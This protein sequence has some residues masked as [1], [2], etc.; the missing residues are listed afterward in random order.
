[1]LFHG[2]QHL[3]FLFNES[4][5]PLSRF[6]DAAAFFPKAPVH[7]DTF[8]VSKVILCTP[9]G[10]TYPQRSR[11]EGATEVLSVHDSPF[12]SFSAVRCTPHRPLPK[13]SG[14]AGGGSPA[15]CSSFFSGI[16]TT[17]LAG[18]QGWLKV[19]Q[20]TLNKRMHSLNGNTTL[21]IQHLDGQLTSYVELSLDTLLTP[22]AQESAC[23]SRQRLLELRPKVTTRELIIPLTT[24]QLDSFSTP[25]TSSKRTGRRRKFFINNGEVRFRKLPK[26]RRSHTIKNLQ[27]SACRRPP[28]PRGA[29][30]APCGSHEECPQTVVG[31]QGNSRGAMRRR[32]QRRAY[33]RWCR[34]SNKVRGK[35][36][37]PPSSVPAKPKH[38]AQTRAKWFRQHIFWQE[39]M[40]RKKTGKATNLPTTTPLGYAEVVRFGALSVQGFADTLKLKNSIQLMQEHRL[41]V[42]FMSETKSTS[43]YSYLSEQ[44]LVILSGNN[45]QK[46]AG[47]GAI[48]SPRIR[49]HLLD[50]IQVSSRLI[51]L[52]FKKKGGNIHLLGAY[53]PHS[54]LDLEEERQPFW[55][56]LEETI[57]KIPQPEPVYV[58]GDFNVRFQ[59]SHKHDAGVLGPFVYGKGSRYIDHNASS[60]RSLCVSVLQR[61]DMLEVASFKTPNM[62]EHITYRDKAAPPK[63]WS[64]FLLDP[65]ILQQLYDRIHFQ[66]GE[67]ALITAANIRSFLDMGSLLPATKVLP[68]LDPTLFQRLDHTFTRKQWLGSVKQCRSKLHTGFPS[69]HYLLVT[70]VKVKLAARQPR[71]PRPPK[72]NVE[73]T[74]AHKK[75]FNEIL[76]DLLTDHTAFSDHNSVGDREGFKGNIFTDGSGSRG[77]CTKSTPAGWGW[78]YEMEGEWTEAFGPVVTESDHPAYRGAQVGSNNTGELTAILEAILYAED[79]QWAALTVHTDSLWSIK[80]ITGQWRPQRH[81]SLIN[82][83][84][85]VIRNIPL[86]VD[87]QWIK[88][89]AGHVGN[90][91]ADKLAEEGKHSLGRYG[92]TAPPL[93]PVQAAVSHQGDFVASLL[94]SSRQTFVPHELSPKRPWITQP[95]LDALAAARRAEA[96]Q[97]HNAKALRNQ[98]KRSARKD[99]IDWIHKR[100]TEDQSQYQQGMWQTARQQKKG[101]QGR[102]R[103]LVVDNKPVPWSQTHKAFR[104]HLQNTQWKRPEDNGTAH[105]VLDAKRQLRDSISDHTS[106]SL[107]DLQGAINKM[108]KRKAPGP[109]TAIN[110]LFMLLDDH[111]S[112]ILLDFYNRIWERGEVP[113]SWKEAIVVSIYKGKGTDTDPSNYRPISLLNSIYKLFAAMLQH[114]LAT[115]HETHLRTTQYGFRASR[116][117][118][119][120]LFILRRAMEWSEMTNNPL[121]F[122]FLDWKQAFDSIDH[123]SMLIALKRFGVSTRALNIIQSLYTDPTFFTTGL[124]GEPAKGTVGSGIRQGCPLS[125]YLFVMVLSVIF[126]DLDW[127][128][129]SRNVP[130]NSW[131]VGKPVYDLEY[132]DDTLMFGMTTTQLQSYLSALETQAALYGLSL[133][134]KKTEVL[135]DSR[136]PT[137]KLHFQDGTTVP[138][139]TQVKYLGSMVSWD[140]PFD[141]AFKHR[142]ALAESAY[143]KLRLVWNSHLPYRERLKIF[144][145]VFIPTLTY[146]LDALTLQDKHLKRIDAFYIRFL[147]RVVKIKASYY[148]R[149]TNDEVYRRAGGP[150]LPSDTMS[151]QQLKILQQVFNSQPENPL[152]HVVLSPAY[153]DRIQA[154]GRRRGGK[155]PY[156]IE[157]TTQR[158][159]PETWNLHPGNGILG[160]NVVY[161]QIARSLRTMSDAA[162]MRADLQRARH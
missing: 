108:K 145:A 56:S 157:I 105:E 140:K 104:D 27:N 93:H 31:T 92:T 119:H 159:F 97:D 75:V 160:P 40:P 147:R 114:R 122:L 156:W 58:T 132:A 68:H 86:K 153:K 127:D 10:S 63:D 54:G 62:M 49:P 102:K 141:V 1:M 50:V 151:Q 73:S 34:V 129:L 96:A 128:L 72:L 25:S 64:Q 99:R 13:R 109:D 42:L 4:Q 89:H 149:I 148:S 98:A 65:L 24:T 95:T 80:V 101:F 158:H 150:K 6:I 20:S 113:N 2:A 144:Q 90:E 9:S 82:Y 14:R 154:T 32:A 28:P 39:H 60:N 66:C 161:G 117:T 142:A 125:P 123:N 139:T 106:F 133:N 79:K 51:H 43:Y 74:D 103:H 36:P 152:H 53:G 22:T 134:H 21:R 67:Y 52:C 71:P 135:H 126:E 131:S 48:I 45:R 61:L 121:Y 7:N 115:Q 107:E 137:P 37:G 18:Q 130:T 87:M 38:A 118:I 3:D 162:P 12:E 116:G 112:L 59:A 33:R 35:G 17:T 136:R 11:R 57:S 23:Y 77:R 69:D 85:S 111:N 94:E 29:P 5:L 47:V 143:K 83:I 88:G 81:K 100:L 19:K 146:G 110:E 155:I 46:H 26:H 44:Y 16:L 91:R 15:C 76:S 78:C 70:D 138:T 84:R 30:G 41:D 120:P 55:D 124:D 8:E